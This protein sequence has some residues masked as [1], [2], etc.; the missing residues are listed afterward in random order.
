MKRL[1]LLGILLAVASSVTGCMTC[2]GY[3]SC[4]MAPMN[5][6]STCEPC[7]TGCMT[8]CPAKYVSPYAGQYYQGDECGSPC[9]GCSSGCG[10]CSVG[11]QPFARLCN[12]LSMGGNSCG[13]AC[14]S[15]YGDYINN[16]P[17]LCNPCDQFGGL[18]GFSSQ[19]SG[20]GCGGC[21]GCDTCSGMSYSPMSY[22]AAMPY[23]P[24]SQPMVQPAMMSVPRSDCK[25]C[26]KGNTFYTSQQIRPQPQMQPM[27][28]QQNML[29][30]RNQVPMQ[31]QPVIIA[32]AR[33]P[34][35]QP[36]AQQPV[37]QD[38][39]VS[40]GNSQQINYRMQPVRQV[41]VRSNDQFG[42]KSKVIQPA[43]I[44][45]NGRVVHAK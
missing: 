1:L 27:P 31:Q 23:A 42:T 32:Q 36:M 41:A 20:G 45:T 7:M 10:S 35:P 40:T 2:G 4:G 25:D 38:K 12:L 19:C 9:G 29:A 22:G 30:V 3:S 39:L 34:Y 33:R 28:V 15:Y 13:C 5:C 21:G 8:A 17:S 44:P 14:E 24:I 6:Y 43:V 16:P 37:L 18:A 26:N 11:Y